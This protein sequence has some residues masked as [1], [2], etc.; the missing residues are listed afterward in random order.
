M[1]DA[2][3]NAPPR[4]E[5]ARPEIVNAG[6]INAIRIVLQAVTVACVVAFT[7]LICMQVFY[8]YVLNSSLIWSEE[9]VRFLLLWTVMLGSAIAT[10][11]G[12]HIILNPLDEHLGP[13]GRRIR[14][15]VAELCTIAFCSVLFWTG[16]QF[17]A[18]TKNMTSSAADIPMYY[19][20]LSM[21]VGA[22]L[23]AF[24]ATIHILAGT[25]HHIDPMDDRS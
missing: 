23:I 9:V 3:S 2:P 8:R 25:V 10:D 16:C 24:F 1:S 11:K 13:G 14:A 4:D 17:I 5:I 12:A 20:Y 7:M 21:P 19:V 6:W 22:M 15:A 18:R